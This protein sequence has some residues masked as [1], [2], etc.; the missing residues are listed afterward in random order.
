MEKEWIMF[1]CSVFYELG[2]A[3]DN[4]EEKA[5]LWQAIMEYWLFWKEPPEKFKRDFVNVRFI[6]EKNK[7]IKQKRSEAWKLH[8]WNQYT[9]WDEKRKDNSKAQTNTVEQ[10]EQLGTNGTNKNKNKNI[11]E[12]IK[13]KLEEPKKKY[14]DFVYLTDTQYNELLR[15]FW[16]TKL[17]QAIENLNN[18]IWEYPKKWSKYASHYHT[19]RKRNQDFIQEK[20]KREK[21][22]TTQHLDTEEDLLWTI[23]LKR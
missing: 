12:N 20:L 15:I 21:L 13:E 5:E 19:I 10:M 9:K 17:N 2:M 3:C 18:Y 8:T 6:L 22:N 16:E 4:P 23:V 14:L 11:K 1:W 7:S